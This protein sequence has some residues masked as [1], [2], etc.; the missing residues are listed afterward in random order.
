[1]GFSRF[2]LWIFCEKINMSG[3]TREAEGHIKAAEKALKTGLLKWN[4]DYD[5]A[6][7]AYS[8]AATSF[9][10]GGNK[11][12]AV[13]SLIKACDCYKEMRSLF[14]AARMLEQAVLIRY[15]KTKFFP[16]TFLNRSR[17]FI[18]KFDQCFNIFFGY[19][20]SAANLGYV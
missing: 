10:V 7:D 15:E 20:C 2:F 19:R 18:E 8:R 5:S 9:K 16:P 6:G 17:N 3:K 1:L 4:P 14:Q 12:K 11:E 13:E